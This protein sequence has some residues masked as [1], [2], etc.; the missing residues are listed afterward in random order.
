MPVLMFQLN[1]HSSFREAPLEERRLIT[2]MQVSH[3][4]I[5]ESKLY[6]FCLPF[7][8]RKT[9]RLTYFSAQ[10]HF[11]ISKEK[12]NTVNIQWRR[13]SNIQRNFL[14]VE[15][16][17]EEEEKREEEIGNVDKKKLFG[18]SFKIQRSC[19]QI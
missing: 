7:Q 14:D 18:S 3:V 13:S 10:E 15:E 5:N 1:T 17:N 2:Q 12:T 9:H 19:H 4:K 11:Y 16:E 8:I 6:S